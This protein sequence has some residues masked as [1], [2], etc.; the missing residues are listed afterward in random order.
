LVEWDFKWNTRKI[1]AA[2]STALIAKGAAGRRLMYE[3]PAEA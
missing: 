2:E 3:R 1:S